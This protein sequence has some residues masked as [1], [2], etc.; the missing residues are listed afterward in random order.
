LNQEYGLVANVKSPPEK[1]VSVSVVINRAEEASWEAGAGCFS[2]VDNSEVGPPAS[3]TFT[4]SNFDE[5]NAQIIPWLQG[6]LA[7]LLNC[8]SAKVEFDSIQWT[9]TS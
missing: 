6:M 8:T 3:L 9:P 5:I 7:Y 2:N 4:A 1:D